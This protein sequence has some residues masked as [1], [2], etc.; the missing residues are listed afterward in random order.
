MTG[1]LT[2]LLR[3]SLRSSWRPLL[4]LA[5]LVGIAGGA[6]LT[7]WEATRRTDSAFAR[8]VESTEAWDVL[9]NPDDG[10]ASALR[11]EDV[12]ALPQVE[13]IGRVDG[14]G[15]GATHVET[16]G[17]IESGYLTLA[18]DGIVGY[19]LAR[20]GDLE[21]RMPALDATDEVFLSRR[22]A[23]V[24]D[25]EVGDR[26]E[27]RIVPFQDFVDLEEQLADVEGEEEALAAMNDPGFGEIVD[28]E[29]VGIGTLFDEVVVGTGF[30]TGTML[31][32]PGVYEA[33]GEPSARFWG[34]N[35]RLRPGA[36]VDE[37]R[38]AVEAL[39]PDESVAF[40]T[41]AS[42]TDEAERAIE[43]QVRALGIFTVI[44]AL[45]GLVVVGQAVSRRVQL[46]SIALAPL[47]ALGVVRRERSAL[48]V[49][50]VAVAAGIGAV[51]SVGVAA[52]ASP[53]SP[54]GFARDAEPDP[55]FWDEWG[56][57]LPGAALIVLAVVATSVWPALQA[58]RAL[59]P[60]SSR[61]RA[62]AWAAGAG[63]PV[64]VVAGTRFALDP[65][66]RGV[67]TRST[68]VGAATS[69]VLVVA[70]ITFA[71]SL[72]HF[73]DSPRLYGTGWDAVVA[74]EGLED[75]SPEQ[76]DEILTALGQTDGVEGYGLLLP[77]QLSL[78][79]VSL[80]AMA[81]G[82]SELAVDPTVLEGRAVRSDD[83]VT[84]GTATLDRLGVEVGDT[85]TVD[86]GGESSE[87]T[88][89][90]R[91]ALPSVAAY[92]GADKT[93]LGD[94]AWVTPGVLE[95]WSPAFSPE[96]AV[97]DVADGVDVDRLV[98]GLD[99][100][101]DG[102]LLVPDPASLPSAVGGLERVRATPL[103]LTGLL[104]VLITVTVVHALGAA[105]RARRRD[106]AVLRTLGF[107]RG[108]VLGAVATQ[109]TLIAVV[110]LVVGVPTGIVA[111]RLAWSWVVDWLGGLV[112]LVTPVGAVGLL[113]LAVL[114]LANLV[115]LFP[116]VRAARAHPAAIL[117]TE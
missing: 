3:S 27:V 59:A 69:V 105:V 16:L 58:T 38:A 39:V 116:G 53:L 12:A 44:A 9:I 90:G 35:V 37:F 1:A 2:V 68:L 111:G 23:E 60:S 54:V 47:R 15:S 107:T 71:A 21:G 79:G 102:I 61:G 42:I 20:P 74:A 82:P 36:E 57:V 109:A 112:D 4:G 56:I 34:M 72:D 101:G 100:P 66:P 70:T 63:L 55:G 40:Q 19:E 78:D 99:E 93:Q 18:T 65:G 103:L 91:V 104:V 84:L 89:V 8:L 29:V 83:E 25:V 32:P 6:V 114:A 73:I 10:T 43:P 24:N 46:D 28:F 45:V 33:L 67:P 88:V 30:T 52:L 77:G 64:P 86:R 49:G 94:G 106:L 5:V 115:S 97:L 108:Q 98:A 81:L 26:V 76:V 17:D 75:P 22:G 80:P 41:L 51:L 50:R 48:V 87:L 110:G 7:G 31:M 14:V 62:S 92:P 85:V 13:E 96:G 117:R 113:A 95:Q 11:L